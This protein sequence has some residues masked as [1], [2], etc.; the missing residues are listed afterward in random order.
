LRSTKLRFQPLPSYAIEIILFQPPQSLPQPLPGYAAT[1]L[2]AAA[3]P[4]IS[5]CRMGALNRM[6]SHPALSAEGL[7]RIAED[8]FVRRAG[9]KRTCRVPQRPGAILILSKTPIFIPAPA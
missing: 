9:M 8:K 3:G 7:A 1:I 2:G 6:Q 4:I 5:Q